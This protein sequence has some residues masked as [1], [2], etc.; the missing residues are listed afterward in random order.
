[1]IFDFAAKTVNRKFDASEWK[2]TKP[3]FFKA[4]NFFETMLVN[5]KVQRYYS[6]DAPEDEKFRVVFEVAKMGLVDENGDAVLTDADFEAMKNAPAA[7]LVRIWQYALNPDYL[8]ET[9]KKK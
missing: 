6:D 3:I 4:L 1:M 8:A 5:E 9:F 7:P 2:A